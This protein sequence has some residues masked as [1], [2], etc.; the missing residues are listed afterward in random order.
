[1]E[2]DTTT[3]FPVYEI[4][5]SYDEI[6]SATKTPNN[7]SNVSCIIRRSSRNVDPPKFYGERFFLDV[8]DLP[9]STSG[10]ASNPII[11]ENF[12]TDKRDHNNSVITLKVVTIDF[13]S[14]TPDRIFSSSTYKSLKMSV[15]N[16]EEQ[17]ELY[18]E[19][20]NIVL[21]NFLNCYR[22]CK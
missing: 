9:Q 16:F 17:S 3:S 22:K 18:S 21:E 15:D 20:F 8:V 6:I 4:V 13:E 1:M 12:D 11:L 14:S 10:S 5:D 19:F 7:P 2:E